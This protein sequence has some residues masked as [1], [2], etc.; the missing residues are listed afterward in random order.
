MDNTELSVN[1]RAVEPHD[2]DFLYRIENIPQIWSISWGDAPVSRQ[3]LWDYINSYT[4]DIYKDRQLRMMI[5]IG[6]EAVGTVDISDFDPRNSRAMLG[7]AIDPSYQGKGIATMALEMVIERCRTTFGMH[8]LAVMIPK[9]NKASLHLF[10]K[11]GFKTAGCLRSWQR[12]GK[13]YVD[14]VLMQLMLN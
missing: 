10:E 5:D 4:A 8:Q 6:N 13:R 1:I 12:R 3:M 7:I 9:D 11:L 14:V 2:I